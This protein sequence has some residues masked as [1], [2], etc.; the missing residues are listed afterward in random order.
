M[1]NSYQA[2]QSNKVKGF[3]ISLMIHAALILIFLFFYL[4][5]PNPPLSEMGLGGGGVELN[6]GD[7]LAGTHDL[8]NL[9]ASNPEAEA[10]SEELATPEPVAEEHTE[11]STTDEGE[12]VEATVTEHED[13]VA[14]K[15][16]T[17]TTVKTETPVKKEEPKVT[18]T[19]VVNNN[20]MM[21]KKTGSTNKSGDD[22]NTPGDPGQKEGTL[23][24]KALMGKPGKGGDGTSSGIGL[25]G[26]LVGWKFVTQPSVVDLSQEKG[27]LI[28]KIYV[29]DEGIIEVAKVI[30]NRGGIT[31]S[32]QAAYQKALVGVELSL[33]DPN[34]KIPPRSEGTVT[35]E[36]RP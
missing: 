19:P 34:K 1:V 20:A 6:L 3:T 27:T 31:P 7:P 22:K 14:I 8:S 35:W 11:E 16:S 24:G 25:G 17:K 33:I 18:P 21:K 23:D 9:T 29:N 32:L 28:F 2:E 5:P 13:A 15:T 4:T 26:G 12:N 10:T 30:E 36:I